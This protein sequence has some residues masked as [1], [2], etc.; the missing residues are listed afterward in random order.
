MTSHQD[1]RRVAILLWQRLALQSQVP[2]HN[3]ILSKPAAAHILIAYCAHTKILI[4]HDVT[5]FMR[6]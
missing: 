3:K 2:E 1:R 4:I 5:C 6:S